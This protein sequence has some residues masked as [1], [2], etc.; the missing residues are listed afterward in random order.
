MADPQCH[1]LSETCRKGAGKRTTMPVEAKPVVVSEVAPIPT[2]PCGA[3]KFLRRKCV[4]GCIF[5]PHFGSDQG[6]AK[7]AAVHKV[8]GASNVSKLLLHIP[9]NRRHD[10]VVTISYEAQARLS[11]PVYGCVSTI[12]SLQQQ[13]A[14]LQA[15]LVMVQN[16]LINSR[17]AMANALQS[18]QQQ[19]HHHQHHHQQQQQQHLALL[20]PAYSNNSSASNNLINMSNFASNFD[21]VA[22]TTTAP[23]SSQS[24]DH[25]QLSRPCHDDE[26]DEQDSRIPPVFVNPIIHRT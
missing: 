13:V 22:E 23:N 21:L 26:D 10:A 4:S 6:A 17:F 5:A 7:F 18:S 11:D 8:F 25:L 3:C 19:Q 12:L 15:E 14:S 1:G 2:A 9:M 24:M 16:Q 20:Q